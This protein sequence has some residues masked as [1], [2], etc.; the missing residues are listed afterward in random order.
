MIVLRVS[1]YRRQ[2]FDAE[3]ER[4]SD[5]LTLS[6]CLAFFC[7]VTAAIIRLGIRR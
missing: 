4:Q 3:Q 1:F 2:S 7:S 5:E 6:Q